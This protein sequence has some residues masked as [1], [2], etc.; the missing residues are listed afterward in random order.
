MST[1]YAQSL[2]VANLRDFLQKNVFFNTANVFFNTV[3]VY[4]DTVK[5]FFSTPR[6]PAP[7]LG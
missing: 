2:S 6:K 4:F 5:K 3:N 1:V 7:R